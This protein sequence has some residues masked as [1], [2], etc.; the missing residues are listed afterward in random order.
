MKISHQKDSFYFLLNFVNEGHS[1]YAQILYQLFNQLRTSF[2]ITQKVEVVEEK[3]KVLFT[4][5]L[6]MISE[7]IKDGGTHFNNVLLV[8]DSIDKVSD[9]RYKDDIPD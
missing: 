4:R 8:F 2:N 6:E 3:L 1:N 9:G 7:K 5:W